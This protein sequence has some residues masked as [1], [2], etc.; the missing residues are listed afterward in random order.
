MASLGGYIQGPAASS[1][2]SNDKRASPS[3]PPPTSPTSRL[4]PRRY[5]SSLTLSLCRRGV[6]RPRGPSPHGPPTRSWNEIDHTIVDGYP[7][8]PS[9]TGSLIMS[10]PRNGAFASMPVLAGYNGTARAGPRVS[11]LTLSPSAAAAAPA[12]RGPVLLASLS[13]RARRHAAGR[14][15]TR[16]SPPL[17][18]SQEDSQGFGTARSVGPTG[19]PGATPS[20]APSSS[21]LAHTPAAPS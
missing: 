10:V 18:S 14:R 16:P 17:P 9:I 6:R 20:H 12:L 2:A 19:L 8:D 13:A 7:G 15:L 1:D 4:P 21:P 3:P 11:T 5:G